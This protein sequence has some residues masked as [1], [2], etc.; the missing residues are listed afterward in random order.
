LSPSLALP[1]PTHTD[2]AHTVNNSARTDAPTPVYTFTAHTDNTTT[3]ITRSALTP[4]KGKHP[5]S[6][7]NDLSSSTP[8]RR[9]TQKASKKALVLSK[10]EYPTNDAL[11]LAFEDPAA[12]T[13]LPSPF[14]VDSSRALD[15]DLELRAD[16]PGF[17]C[18]SRPKATSLPFEPFSLL[19]PENG[20][21][22]LFP[23]S[24]APT[25][26]RAPKRKS[27]VSRSTDAKASATP[28]VD[29]VTQPPPNRSSGEHRVNKK[30]KRER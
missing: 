29:D 30:V 3:P 5:L 9:K 28:V 7:A 24:V 13:P 14:S 6:Y 20:D 25:T 19:S 12:P 26:E 18:D 4:P 23:H 11:P 21:D 27:C 1:T 22:V 16:L 17:L 2:T 10:K 15:F 8:I